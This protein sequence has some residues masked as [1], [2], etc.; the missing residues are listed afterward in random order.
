MLNLGVVAA[1]VAING[2]TIYGGEIIAG[3]EAATGVM[4]DAVS[5]KDVLTSYEATDYN[6]IFNYFGAL[7]VGFAVVAVYLYQGLLAKLPSDKKWS[8]RPRPVH[9]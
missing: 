2:I 6:P 3:L 4:Y 1:I 8:A 9:Q 7:S 5:A